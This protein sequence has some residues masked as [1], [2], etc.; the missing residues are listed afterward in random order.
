[1]KK[2]FVFLF[3]MF[4]VMTANAQV[5]WN[6]KG[7]VGMASCI[8]SGDAGNSKLKFVAKFGGGL[9]TPITQSLSFMPSL[10]VAWKGG[11]YKMY[12]G[13]A[14]LNLIYL[15]VPAVL[16]YRVN[17]NDRLNMTMKAGP[18]VAFA[19]SGNMK[20]DY[21]VGAMAYHYD[22]NIFD[23]GEN[24]V[25]KAAK[26]FDVGLDV[27]LDFELHRFVL[28]LEYELGFVSFAP[29]DASLKNQAFYLTVGYKF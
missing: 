19:V 15:Q 27:G 10:E 6:L 4:A 17:V 12:D 23:E 18:Y 20:Q 16:A 22:V 5:T 25:A 1:M 13:D 24:G 26:R 2:L 11:K 7:G 28:G 9:E 3:V 21:T 8:S 29:N 14:T